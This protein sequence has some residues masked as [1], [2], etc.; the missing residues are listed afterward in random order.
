MCAAPAGG[1]GSRAQLAPPSVVVTSSPLP[2][3]QPWPAET[4]LTSCTSIGPTACA[5]GGAEAGG[6]LAAVAEPLA[7]TAVDGAVDDGTEAGTGDPQPARGTSATSATSATS[8]AA[9]TGKRLFI[10]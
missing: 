3:A 7:V 2:S 5:L 9:V 6:L 4:K 1:R 10:S 8:T